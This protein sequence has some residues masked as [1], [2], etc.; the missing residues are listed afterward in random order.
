MQIVFDDCVLGI[1]GTN[2]EYIFSYSQGGP[3]SL[4]ING[5]EWVY[6]APKPTFWRATTCNDRGNHFSWKSSMWLGADMFITVK[7]IELYVDGK[8]LP[9]FR[10]PFNNTLIGTP[11]EH[12]KSVEII[13][14]YETTTTPATNVSVQYRIEETGKITVTASYEGKPELPELP[15]FGLRF[16]MP[17]AADGYEYTGISGETYPDRMAGGLQ[18]AYRIPGLPVTPYL[19][20]QECGMHMQTERVTVQLGDAAFRI[21]KKDVPFAFSALPYTAEEL[22]NATHHEELPPPR[23]TVLCIY[24]AVRGVGG[25]DSWGADVCPEYH[26]DAGINHSFTFVIAVE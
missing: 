10:A 15:A 24:G 11:L 7:N 19:V 6:R 18:G 8:R 14:R 2:F 4:K 21:T 3:E 22:E 9:D 26:I 23:R 17:D 12:P 1:H 13:Y 5:T 16:I 20:P 25:I